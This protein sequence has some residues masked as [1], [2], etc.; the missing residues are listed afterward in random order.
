MDSEATYKTIRKLLHIKP[1]ELSAL[2]FHYA[3]AMYYISAAKIKHYVTL[4]CIA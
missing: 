2:Y 4:Y 1:L 3:A